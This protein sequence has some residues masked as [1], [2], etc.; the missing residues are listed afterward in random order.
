[1]AIPNKYRMP[2]SPDGTPDQDYMNAF[3][4]KLEQ[5][6]NELSHPAEAQ[7]GGQIFDLA[8]LP[9]SGAGLRPGTVFQDGGILRVVRE[10]D[11]F[12]PSGAIF[13]AGGTVTVITT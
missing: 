9:G 8:S 5:A 3:I 12:A 1:M 2:Q 10:S 6:L 4:R 13:V 11:V 7:M